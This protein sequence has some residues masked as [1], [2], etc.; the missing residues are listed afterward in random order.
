MKSILITGC[1]TGFGF[2]AAK[3]L[4]EKGHKVYASMR[5]T[6]SKNA[7]PAK[8]LS[9]FARSKNLHL[10]VVDLD[11]T[12]D[13][14]VTDAMKHIDDCDVLINNAGRGFGGPTEGFTTEECIA[15]LDLNVVGNIRMI[16]AVLPGMRA[17]KS[18]LIIQLSSI[19]GRL[20]IPGFGIYCASK[21]AV[22]ALSESLRLELGP[23]GI[24]VAIV[25]PGPFATNF[26]PGV[27]MASDEEVA[28]AYE[29]VNAFNEGFAN[30]ANANF[31]DKNVPTDPMIVVKTFEKLI[32]TPAGHRPMRT[33]AGLDFGVQA[34]NDAM[35]PHRKGMLENFGI[36]DWDGVKV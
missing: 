5:N 33:L 32:D 30:N 10:K 35:E 3:Y 27:V 26:L 16:K 34:I 36:S 2:E 24:D 25:Q 29:H 14:S 13:Q 21:W 19:A 12:S 8:E 18:G 7:K 4:A 1:S 20:S 11:V 22:E 15:Q 28:K 9:D 31:E 17:R 6:Y 23:L